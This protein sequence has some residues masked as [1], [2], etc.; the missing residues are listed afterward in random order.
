MPIVYLCFVLISL[1]V[2][3]LNN[4]K[5][6]KRIRKP[7][8]WGLFIFLVCIMGLRSEYVGADSVQYYLS[9]NELN[10]MSLQDALM[11]RYATGYILFV[12]FVGFFTR[13]PYCFFFIVSFATLAIYFRFF[14][15][16]SV[17]VFF[18]VIVFFCL[19]WTDFLVLT[20]QAC[21]S[22]L[23][24]LG[25]PFLLDDRK[26]IY[27]LFVL[28]A[29]LFHESAIIALTFIPLFKLK[30]TARKIV[31]CLLCAFFC[32]EFFLPLLWKLIT[33]LNVGAYAAY[34]NSKFNSAGSSV[35]VDLLIK[36]FPSLLCLIYGYWSTSQ[37][38]TKEQNFFLSL[39]LIGL[40]FI[41]IGMKTLILQRLGMYFNIGSVIACS[42]L[43]F[44]K[45][46]KNISKQ[47]LAWGLVVFSVAIFSIIQ[48][49]RPTWMRISPY[50]PFWAPFNAYGVDAIQYFW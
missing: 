47:I 16:Y 42:Y 28:G 22:C 46:G 38:R 45:G 29:M 4:D 48:I 6:L 43:F 35:F 15:K 32:A 20:R 27:A 50:S 2:F 39:N 23:I 3:V 1:S 10:Q 36:V 37:E 7:F 13:S 40:C 5:V 33:L 30:M 18:S 41:I 49:E 24:C 11:T 25:I 9:F 8:F 17:N 44:S 12:R 19:Y 31:V 26:K 21:A 14:S 34:V